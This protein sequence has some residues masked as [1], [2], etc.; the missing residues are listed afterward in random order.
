MN[1]TF[2]FPPVM[3]FKGSWEPQCPGAPEPREPREPQTM[4]WNFAEDCP[5]QLTL[6]FI[7]ALS[8]LA[9]AFS[10]SYSQKVANEPKSDKI[11]PQCRTPRA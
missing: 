6:I 3:I 7:Y 9:Y 2:D 1:F 10:S 8:L 11:V 4:N 5:T